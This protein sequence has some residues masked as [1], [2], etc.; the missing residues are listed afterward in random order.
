MGADVIAEHRTE[1]RRRDGA[2]DDRG[3]AAGVRA[4]GRLRSTATTTDED[5]AM[6]TDVDA[7]GRDFVS[8]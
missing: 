3:D 6:L 4:R 2:C 1:T 7:R 5:A 8:G